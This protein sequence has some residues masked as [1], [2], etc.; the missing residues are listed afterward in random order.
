M[1][2]KDI[3]K[4][5]VQVYKDKELLYSGMVDD[6]PEEIKRQETESMRIEHKCLIIEVK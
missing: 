4:Y 5:N 1:W 2:I 6:A 3:R